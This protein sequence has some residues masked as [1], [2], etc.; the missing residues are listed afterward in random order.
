MDKTLIDVLTTASEPIRSLPC[1]VS[2]MPW[3]W[4]IAACGARWAVR[5]SP[6]FAK[7]GL[8]VL[9]SSS[10]PPSAHA[11]P[12]IKPRTSSHVVG[13]EDIAKEHPRV[14][15]QRRVVRVEQPGLIP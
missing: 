10:Q 7:R 12:R 14:E 6:P 13:L 5:N 11:H 2:K 9:I 15:E 4:S 8:V 1:S 3:S